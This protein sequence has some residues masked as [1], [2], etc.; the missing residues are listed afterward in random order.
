MLL[1]AVDLKL[2]LFAGEVV[3]GLDLVKTIES[4]GTG[5]GKPKATIK[6]SRSGTC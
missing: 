1:K 3:E 2:D 4:Y 6:I 5:S